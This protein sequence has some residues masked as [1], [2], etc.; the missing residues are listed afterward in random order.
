MLIEKMNIGKYYLYLYLSERFILTSLIT[1]LSLI[2]FIQKIE[3][4]IV[5]SL[6]YQSSNAIMIKDRDIK[7]FIKKNFAHLKVRKYFIKIYIKKS[8]Y[9]TTISNEQTK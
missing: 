3:K 1:Y 7:F 5:F 6:D 8:F 2:F 9:K 4:K